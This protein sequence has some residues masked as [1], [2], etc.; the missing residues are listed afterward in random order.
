M[1]FS[2]TVSLT[3]FDKRS[4]IERAM[5]RCR[6]AAQQITPEIIADASEELY[7]M[8][9]AWASEQT[10]LWC[11]EKDIY[12]LYEGV[13]EV[14]MTLGTADIIAANL[15]SLQEVTGTDTDT[16][17]Q[18][19]VSFTDETAV[20]T[21]G[22]K[23]SAASSPLEFARSTDGSTWTVI[24]TETP[25]AASGEWSWYD[26]DSIVSAYY[27]RVRATSGTLDFEDIYLG[28]TP[29]E[30]P[31]GRWSLDTWTNTPLRTS[32]SERPL[33]YWFDRRVNQPILRLWPVPNAD[34]ETSQIVVWKQRY[35]MDVGTMRQD[36]EVPQRWLD[37]VVWG[38]A[39]RMVLVTP[40]A[41]LNLMPILENKAAVALAIAQ[42]EE[43]DN[44]PMFITPDIGCYT[45]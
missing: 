17:T 20:S 14:T 32:Q 10:P 44:S 5:A 18:R 36:V 27:F 45:R 8:L 41:D 38:L 15:R 2:D 6:F 3:V 9:S 30:V 13:G 19:S 29:G 25:S 37:A 23:W 39:A 40:Q 4:V 43:V 21:V 24:Q 34:A 35:I 12:P 16:S 11:I 42:Q 1:A 33:N 31:L 22:I 7:L 26:L 28:N